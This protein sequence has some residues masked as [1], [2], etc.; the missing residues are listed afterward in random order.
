[1]FG[2]IF[3]HPPWEI[4]AFRQDNEFDVNPRDSLLFEIWMVRIWQWRMADILFIMALQPLILSTQS[5]ET[6]QV[7]FPGIAQSCCQYLLPIGYLETRGVIT[8]G[9]P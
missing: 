8:V 3:G 5:W 2:A 7:F 6:I 1:M 9:T 4:P